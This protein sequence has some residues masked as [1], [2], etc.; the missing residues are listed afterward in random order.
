MPLYEFEAA[1]GSRH[2]WYYPLREMPPIG[3]WRTN[4]A[5]DGTKVRAR[6]VFSS[7]RPDVKNWGHVSHQLPRF[8]SREQA[9]KLG[10]DCDEK[11]RP[12][13]S[14]K[15]QMHEYAAKSRGRFKFD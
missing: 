3:A 6:R 9:E 15:Q 10:F 11:L 4:V 5:L 12:R 1:D 7:A 14:N 2:E 13:F 8:A